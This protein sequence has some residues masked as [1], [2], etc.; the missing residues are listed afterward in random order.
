MDEL[1]KN[2]RYDLYRKAK[3]TFYINQWDEPFGMEMLESL[4]CATPNIALRKGAASEVI[5]EKKTGFLVETEQEMIEAVKNIDSIDPSI[6]RK[7]A[8]DKFSSK[9]I[10]EKYFNLYNSLISKSSQ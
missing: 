9:V 7:I 10:T 3:G 2:A 6:C 5:E 8:E 4:A 1:P